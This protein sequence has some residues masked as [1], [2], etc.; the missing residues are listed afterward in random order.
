LIPFEEFR[1][2]LCGLGFTDKRA[3]TAWVFHHP[4]EG[5]LVF[6]LYVA[7]DAVDEGDLR[8]TRQFLDRR[9]LLPAQDFD[10]FVQRASAPA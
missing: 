3:P 10:T 2:F 6:R 7:D 4:E 8:S 9:G 5:L 1:R